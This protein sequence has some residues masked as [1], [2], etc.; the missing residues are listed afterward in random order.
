MSAYNLAA[1]AVIPVEILSFVSEQH[2]D[3]WIQRQRPKPDFE[4]A[5]TES[6]P[7][8][9]IYKVHTTKGFEYVLPIVVAVKTGK[10][11]DKKRR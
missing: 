4:E 10:K 2:R 5:E 9:K 6:F 7:G 11:E 3:L 1:T 8:L